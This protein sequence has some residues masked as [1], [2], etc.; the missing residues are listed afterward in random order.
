MAHFDDLVLALPVWMCS[1]PLIGLFVV[2]FLGGADWFPCCS[3]IVYC[4]SDDLLG[5]L[6][7]ED[8]PEL[9]ASVTQICAWLS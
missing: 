3:Y 2:P 8:L 9:I 6:W 1:L 4:H 5:N 7:L